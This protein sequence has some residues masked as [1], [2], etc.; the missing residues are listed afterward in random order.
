M[1]HGYYS[2]K[3]CIAKIEM[4]QSSIEGMNNVQ[5]AVRDILYFTVISS[6][7]SNICLE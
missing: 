2:T 6:T 7:T 5:H 3:N 4:Y 1:G